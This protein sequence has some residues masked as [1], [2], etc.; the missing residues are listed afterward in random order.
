MVMTVFDKLNKVQISVMAL[1]TAVLAAGCHCGTSHGGSSGGTYS[2]TPAPYSSSYSSA[3]GGAETKTTTEAGAATV[4]PLY[5]EN[6]EVGTRQVEQGTVRL[7]KV[8]KTETVNQPVQI[9][10]ETVVIERQP[11]S[12]QPSG[13][14]DDAFKEKEM[15][16][17]LWREEPVVETK[18][19]PA[20]Q[21]VAKRQSE[22]E[23]TTIQRQVRKE[24]IDVDKSGNTQNVTISG[25]LSSTGQ[26]TGEY[27]GGGADASG[28]AAGKAAGGTITE[29]TTITTCPDQKTLANR[30]VHLTNAKVEK[31]ISDRV[32]E[33]HD[34]SG[35]ACYIRLNET[36]PNVKVSDT[37]EVT[38]TAKMIPYGMTDLGLGDEVKTALKGQE[39]FVDAQKFEVTN[40]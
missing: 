6:V 10:K 22:T 7:R 37:I 34:E 17:Q 25:D 29:V 14:M 3:S 4:I 30:N 11:A 33:V 31:V 27:A 1:S 36:M 13:S 39:I 26:A 35:K 16:I 9:R 15:T 40:K 32:V 21:V 19:V 5:Q 18:I 24:D 8:I 12:G 2:Y 23:Q 38:G 20:G 28:Q